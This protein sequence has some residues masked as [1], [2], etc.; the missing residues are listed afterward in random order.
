MS[1]LWT[2]RSVVGGVAAL[3]AAALVR[4]A[5]AEGLL[6]RVKSAGVLRIGLADNLPWSKLNPDGSLTGVAPTTVMAVAARLGIPKI[7]GTIGTYGQLVPG[8]LAGRWD[9]IGSSLTITP[10]R[11]AQVLFSDP[12]Y[13]ADERRYVGYLP[14][15]VQDP[16]TSYLEVAQRFDRVGVNSGSGELPYWYKAIETAGRKVEMVQFIDSQS[17]VDALMIKRVPIIS[18]AMAER[19]VRRTATSAT[20]SSRNNGL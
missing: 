13:R 9:I 19:S 12:F 6:A 14:G 2:R 11:C 7:E 15:T 17:L 5:A 10:E 8:L 16:P 20:S 4:P 3:G 1:S 18:A